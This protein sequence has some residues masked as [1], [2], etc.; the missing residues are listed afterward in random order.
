M[1]GNSLQARFVTPVSGFIVLVVL[2]GALLFSS[3]ESLRLDAEVRSQSEQRIANIMQ[4]LSV[5]DELLQQQTR[6]SMRL[7]M[8][9]GQALGPASLAAPLT[10][11]QRVVPNLQFGSTLMA[12][13]NE[14]VDGLVKLMGGT[15][16]IF[17]K[18]GEDFVRIATNVKVNNQRAT[19][20]VLDPNGR[21]MAALRSGQSFY[22]LVDILGNPYMTA[23]EP[24][25][26]AHGAVIGILYVGYKINLVSLGQA[27]NSSRLLNAGFLAVLDGKGSVRF[28]SS[29]VTDAEVAD[30]LKSELWHLDRQRFSNWGV[31]VIGAYPQA[32]ASGI[33]RQRTFTILGA[34]ILICLVLV[35]L[36]IFLLRRLVL[37]PLGGEPTAAMALAERIAT[38][39]L[40][41]VIP[42][43]SAGARSLM[44]ALAHMQ[45]GLRQ[46]VSGIQQDVDALRVSSQSVATLSAQVTTGA[47]QQNDATSA[48]A[49]SLDQISH[50]I[51]QVA[52]SAQSANDQ[53]ENAGKLAQEGDMVMSAAVTE[54][55][56]SANSVNQSASDVGEL[57]ERS[58]KIGSII[59]VIK[60]IAE[61]TNLLALNAAIEAARAGESGR[62]FAVVAD[63][64]RKLAERTEASTREIYNMINHIQEGTSRAI[65]GIEDGASRVSAS[66]EV[67]E[68][69]G[70]S[71]VEINQTSS[72]VQESVNRISSALHEQS[73]V[74]AQIS[75]NVEQVATRNT[76][77]AHA[78]HG[79]EDNAGV[80]KTLAGQ[81]Q[82]K[83]RRF[84]L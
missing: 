4:L 39:D 14:L 64:V 6:S 17:V 43:H 80:L 36:M 48:I 74:M 73:T 18:S 82:E 2:G 13:N 30:A 50:S 38:G 62:G 58:Q 34:G 1:V 29:H 76:D 78:A 55:R 79:M 51:R 46:M 61:Q 47:D 63:E 5:S 11:N 44:A 53:A 67:A 31:E 66:V 37:K 75:S 49:A 84:T 8:Q 54:M 41:G 20:T 24:I 10:V 59:Q 12:G 15:A 77:N 16:T 57:A 52:E 65:S 40:T 23:Y 19:G 26:D 27:V 35:G 69:L 33:V 56:D 21:A 45:D 3:L 32:E 7:L 70:M 83:V 9:R 71:M 42:V 72:Q 25:R 68:L 22:G 81:L 60:E 28:H